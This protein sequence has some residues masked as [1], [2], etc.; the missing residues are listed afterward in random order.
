[1]PPDSTEYPSNSITRTKELSKVFFVVD[2]KDVD[3]GDKSSE[4]N[5]KIY[6]DLYSSQFTKLSMRVLLTKRAT[7]SCL[8]TIVRMLFDSSA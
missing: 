2:Y 8:S 6:K 3:H 5:I 1:M 7:E 4:Q